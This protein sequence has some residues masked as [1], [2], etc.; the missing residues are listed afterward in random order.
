MIMHMPTMSA[1]PEERVCDAA[2]L[3]EQRARLGEEVEAQLAQPLDDDGA[4]HERQNRDRDA[5]L[6]ADAERA[7]CLL[8]DPPAP[9]PVRADGDVEGVDA[10][11]S[12]SNC[13]PRFLEA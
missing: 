12:R 8:D 1:L 6:T 10:V 11:A 13:P 4:E 7:E 3:A 5:A 2:L 9:Q